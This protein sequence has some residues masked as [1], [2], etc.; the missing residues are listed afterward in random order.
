M[1]AE[2]CDPAFGL[3]ASRSFTL[4]LRIV[5]VSDDSVTSWIPAMA[6]ILD[7]RQ[8]FSSTGDGDLP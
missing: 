2:V 3:E 1:A 6:P 4:L 5:P 7:V 8:A